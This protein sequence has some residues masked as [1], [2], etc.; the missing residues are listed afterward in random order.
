M[1]YFLMGLAVWFVEKRF[2]KTWPMVGMAILLGLLVG[3]L[4]TYVIYGLIYDV[5]PK[6]E[7]ALAMIVNG[8]WF[9][10][11]VLLLA[12]GVRWG[13]KTIWAKSEGQSKQAADET[14]G[15]SAGQAQTKEEE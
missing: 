12:L 13:K 4:G 2:A 10:V 6:G 9:P 3:T 8:F 11:Y 5:N 7:V 1:E 15:E 14:N